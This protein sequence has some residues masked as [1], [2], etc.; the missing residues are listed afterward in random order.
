M[1]VFSI[2]YLFESNAS[3]IKM[4]DSF[5]DSD[6]DMEKHYKHLEKRHVGN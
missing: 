3:F 6:G 1:K 4:S 2:Y 5:S